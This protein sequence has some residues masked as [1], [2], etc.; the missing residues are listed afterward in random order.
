M[1]RKTPAGEFAALPR[2][3]LSRRRFGGFLAAGA[4]WSLAKSPAKA[5]G[6][7]GGLMFTQVEVPFTI[8]QQGQPLRAGAQ[9]TEPVLNRSKIP[10]VKAYRD[11]LD[12]TKRKRQGPD[13]ELDAVQ[14]WVNGHVR[15]MSDYELYMRD[16]VWA[17]PLNTLTLGG[18]CE[19]IALVKRW[20]LVR[21]GFRPEDLA[22]VV[23]LSTLQRPPQ[24][25]AVLGVRLAKGAYRLLDSLESRVLDGGDTS[26]F[27]P[28]YAVNEYGFWK[29][30]Q[31]GRDDGDYVR[32]AFERANAKQR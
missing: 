12:A 27:Q 8:A 15:T 6:L 14:T 4:A 26:H 13:G 21:L 25:H 2:P 28:A 5:D 7:V 11:F 31:P 10:E 9:M 20:G 19:D 1:S 16:D 32:H 18:D 24:P 22:L 17:P 29:V 30:D 23:G 3:T